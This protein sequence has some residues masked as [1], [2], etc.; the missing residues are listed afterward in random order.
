MAETKGRACRGAGLCL[1]A[2]C[3]LAGCLAL[4]SAVPA[5]ASAPAPSELT[6][7]SEAES[8]AA[9]DAAAPPSAD[10]A[11][12][13]LGTTGSAGA[14]ETEAAGA[15]AGVLADAKGPVETWSDGTDPAAASD[16]ASGG[17]D[18]VADGWFEGLGAWLAEN[19][20][21]ALASARAAVVAT[22]E[23]PSVDEDA[24]GPSVFPGAALVSGVVALA[25]VAAAAAAFAAG[26]SRSAS[27]SIAAALRDNGCRNRN[28]I[29]QNEGSSC[30]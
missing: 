1:T 7:A 21:Q 15:G 10:T 27:S 6:S 23:V 4:F 24:P 9:A 30:L 17:A 8:A 12:T 22:R 5:Q 18:P 13:G 11:E 14:G 28:A 16:D 26:R 3:V 25:C 19:D 29:Q 20:S 2:A